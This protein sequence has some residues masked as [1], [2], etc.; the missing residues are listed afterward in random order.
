MTIY[1]WTWLAA[2][3]LIL[4][5]A[6]SAPD[7]LTTPR[8]TVR[9]AP[10]PVPLDEPTPTPAPNAGAPAVPTLGQAGMRAPLPLS[11]EYAVTANRDDHTLSVVPIGLAR[12]VATVSLDAPPRAVATAPDSDTAVTI[13]ET[14]SLSLASLNSSTVLGSVDAASNAVQ[15]VSPPAE[16]S[17]VVLVLSEGDHVQ[18]VDASSRTL[19]PPIQLDA[20][21]HAVSFGR[22]GVPAVPRIF[23]SNADAGTV[24]VLD[25]QAAR[26]D[27]VLHVGG[28]PVGVA[29]TID[30]RLWVAD[31]ASG[32]IV[33]VDTDDGHRIEAIPLG[34]AGAGMTGLS[35]THDGH[36]LVLA[37]SAADHALVSVDLLANALGQADSVVRSLAVDGGVLALA[38]GAETTRAYATTAGGELLYW[39]LVSN[40]IAQTVTVGK[41]PVSL[42]LGMVVPIGGASAPDT[43]A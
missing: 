32:S 38:T 41:T 17:G 27:H 35:A 7:D 18:V 8:P 39:D 2:V 34:A 20:G 31:A 22:A 28:R 37:S 19:G 23:L 1:Q 26:V 12:A 6:C 33:Q 36:Y 13:S 43:S 29:Q 25:A 11:G 24:S 5:S 14:P 4:A 30:S 15:V 42:A 9:P 3:P 40:S 21:P 10:T 16:D